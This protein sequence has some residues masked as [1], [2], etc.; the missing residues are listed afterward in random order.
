VQINEKTGMTFAAG[1]RA[2][3]RQDPD[4]ICVGEIRDGET[5]EIA[6]RSA[7]T[8]HVVL[9][10]IHTSDA[11]GTIERLVDMGVELLMNTIVSDLIVK[12]NKVVVK[13][14]KNEQYTVSSND[15]MVGSKYYT[16]FNPITVDTSTSV[17][18]KTVT[19][20]SLIG[21]YVMYENG[22]IVIFRALYSNLNVEKQSDGII[23]N[24]AKVTRKSN[25]PILK[26][27]IEELNESYEAIRNMKEHVKE[28]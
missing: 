15:Y 22:D 1:L 27:L 6:M 13:L 17:A 20:N 8:G 16:A 21:E 4:I 9:S 12:D 19:F 3:L 2:I 23:T 11:V 7:I 14:P 18:E 26:P 10:T 24:V 28:F 25:S 5:A